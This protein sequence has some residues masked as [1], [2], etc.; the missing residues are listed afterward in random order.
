MMLHWND[1]YFREMWNGSW[2][3]LTL[4]MIIAL[5]AIACDRINKIGLRQAYNDLGVQICV[6]FTTFVTA[7]GLRAGYIWVLLHC[8][9]ISNNCAP[10]EREDWIMT[11]A[12]MVA[13]VGGLCVIRV[14]SPPKWRPWSWLFAGMMS[15][16]V[17]A[18]YYGLG[19]K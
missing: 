9:N 2:F 7:S 17:P 6:S 14:M 5:V 11:V 10:I 12:G 8:Q 18:F 15:I 3:M 19:T 13:I 1:G 4:S 16:G